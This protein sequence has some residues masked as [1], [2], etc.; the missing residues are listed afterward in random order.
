MKFVVSSSVLLKQISALEG[1][2][3]GNPVVPILENF[4][5]EIKDGKLLVTASDLQV[6]VVS[7]L[8]VDVERE[9]SVAIPAK[10]LS[11]TLRNLPEQPVTITVDEEDF[12]VQI[13]SANGKYRLAGE[14]AIDF[15]KVPELENTQSTEVASEVISSA[16]AYTLF[17]TSTDE[18]KPAMNGVYVNI[19]PSQA[20]F[21]ATDGHRLMR[22]KRLDVSS[23]GELEEFIIPRKALTILKKSLPAD[24]TPLQLTYNDQ[25]ASFRFNT[26]QMTCRLIDENFPDYE[27]VIPLDNDKTMRI[28]RTELMSS[29]KRMAIYAN[30]STNQIRLK[31]AGDQ[32]EVSA[33]DIDFSNEAS[34]KL[35]CDF[36]AEDGAEIEIGFNAR[37]LIDGLSNLS[38]DKVAFDFSEPN[39]AALLKPNDSESDEDI[40]MLIMPV[41]LNNYY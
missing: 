8:S 7:E 27:N 14:N 37:F 35:F 33:E 5:F 23:S 11:D 29:L 15:P 31:I 13:F 6:T 21:V 41:M 39:R 10:M 26:I 12:V 20:V 2:V 36:E 1:V 22:Y 38:A 4:L 16:I 9:G 25:H 17:A 3:A 24:D 34:E 18:M 40:L 30:K 32:L 19:S 28:G